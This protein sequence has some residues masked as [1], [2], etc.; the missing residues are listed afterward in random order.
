MKTNDHVGRIQCVLDSLAVRL[1]DDAEVVT[2]AQDPDTIR[3][4]AT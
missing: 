1:R 3:S 4:T 2:K